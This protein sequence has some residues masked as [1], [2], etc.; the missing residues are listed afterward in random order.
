[1]SYLIS[2]SPF[3][4]KVV[5]GESVLAALLGLSSGHTSLQIYPIVEVSSVDGQGGASLGN[6]GHTEGRGPFNV[7]F[8]LHFSFL[9][10]QPIDRVDPTRGL[11]LLWRWGWLGLVWSSPQFRVVHGLF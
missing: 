2:M 6:L 4:G 5:F 10:L 8:S 7:L 1:M 11:P 9:C 3:I